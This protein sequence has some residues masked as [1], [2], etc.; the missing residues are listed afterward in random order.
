M[1]RCGG[2]TLSQAMVAGALMFPAS[3]AIAPSLSLRDAH[4]IN[5]AL[6]LGYVLPLYFTKFTRLSFSKTTGNDGTHSKGAS[7][8]SRDDPGVIKARLLSVSISTIS[9]L[10]LLHYI[11]TAGHSKPLEVS[12]RRLCVYVRVAHNP[13]TGHWMERD[14]PPS[15]VLL[16]QVRS[17]CLLRDASSVPWSVVWSVPQSWPA[18]HDTSA[19]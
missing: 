19:A 14:G 2:G 7:E 15:G 3:Q 5:A 4:L 11:I 9:S 10:F 8:R 6:T 18:L 17:P 13:F 1:R 12:K 16:V